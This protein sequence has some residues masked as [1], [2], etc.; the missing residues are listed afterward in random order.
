VAADEAVDLV[1]AAAVVLAAV[2]EW[3]AETDL[4]RDL[5]ETAFARTVGRLCRTR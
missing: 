4:V 5:A 1:G 3:A 2:A